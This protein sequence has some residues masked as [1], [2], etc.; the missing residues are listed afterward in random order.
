MQGLTSNVIF[1][2]GVVGADKAKAK[3]MAMAGAIAF[4]STQL[5][6]VAKNA[7]KFAL[8]WGQL[9]VAQKRAVMEADQAS[10][11]IIDTFQ[12]VEAR[13][14][15]AKAGIEISGKALSDVVKVSIVDGQK[16]GHSAEQITTD[17]DKIITGLAK[18]QTRVFKEMGKEF[19]DGATQAEV[20]EKG[21]EF[22]AERA[23]KGEVKIRTLSE[24]FF[25]LNNNMETAAGIMAGKMTSSMMGGFSV[26]EELN[27][28]FPGLLV[29]LRQASRQPGIS[30]HRL[31]ALQLISEKCF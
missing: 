17:F 18:G 14:K 21:L 11:G 22:L 5:V 20:A 13:A 30:T 24:G 12:I 29:H 31:R 25:A 2:L 10:K 28:S 9:G 4:V 27:N 6:E 23:E 1:A 15:L 8:A 7:E 19:K 26:I 3:F 16:L